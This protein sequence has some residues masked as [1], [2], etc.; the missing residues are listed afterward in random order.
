MVITSSDFLVVE[1]VRRGWVNALMT[2]R[3]ERVSC[4]DE[5]LSSSEIP[6]G[7]SSSTPTPARPRLVWLSSRDLRGGRDSEILPPNPLLVLD[8][9]PTSILPALMHNSSC[10]RVSA[11][12]LSGVSSRITPPELRFHAFATSSRTRSARPASLQPLPQC[13]P[14]K[15]ASSCSEDDVMVRLCFFVIVRNANGRRM[16]GESRIGRTAGVIGFANTG[17]GLIVSLAGREAI[18][19]AGVANAGDEDGMG[20]VAIFLMLNR[21]AGAC[22]V[23]TESLSSILKKDV[24]L[25]MDGTLKEI[26]SSSVCVDRQKPVECS[27]R[28]H[29]FCIFLDTHLHFIGRRVLYVSR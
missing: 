29:A 5:G 23:A 20:F 19:Y 21:G 13:L 18:G 14:M 25:S 8:R 3:K 9:R 2:L 22:G 11:N 16:A 4:F 24:S 28:Y 1:Y 27:L 7:W 10:F 6:A 15:V 17:G 12:F 26:L